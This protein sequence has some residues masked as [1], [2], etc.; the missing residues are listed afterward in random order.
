MMM[1]PLNSATRVAPWLA[2]TALVCAM[3]VLS[4]D[5][6]R[7]Q[8]AGNLKC[9]KCVNTKDVAKKAITKSR[10]KN[11]AVTFGKLN[12]KVLDAIKQDRTFYVT[13]DSNGAEATLVSQGPLRM[14]AR[15]IINDAGQDRIEIVNT[16]T[17]NG[18]F[19]IT[20]ATARSAGEERIVE[21]FAVPTGTT[22]I[23]R[24]NGVFA[25]GAIAPDG[26]AIGVAPLLGS[27]FNV[28][29]H[30]CLVDGSAK[31]FTGNP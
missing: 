12:P 8:T 18:W 7:A 25:G 26:S 20:E 6:V 27:G 19:V 11:D 5:A 4:P 3:M 30:A 10:L 24:G 17:A 31:A 1:R 13:L 15:C 9:N 21:T 14:F 28:F 16:S 23:I 22:S 29:G 2:A